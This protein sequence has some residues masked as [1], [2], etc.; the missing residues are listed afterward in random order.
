MNNKCLYCYKELTGQVDFHQVCSMEFFGTKEA[1]ELPYSLDQML[2]L[3]KYV[4]E[5][6]VSVPGVQAKLSMSLIKEVQ[7]RNKNRLTVVG[8]LG[9]NYIFKPPNNDFPDMPQNEHATMRIAEAMGLR[10]VPSSLIRLQSGELSYITKRIDRTPEGSKIH[11]L[12]MFQLTDAYDKYKS[13][14]E[15][16]GK[17]I[18]MYSDNTLLDL[19]Y[20]FELTIFSFLTGNN[21]MHLKNFSLISTNSRWILSPAYDLLNVSL[22]NPKDKEELALPIDGKK[23]KLKRMHFELFGSSLGLNS[24]QIS[25]V[26]NRYQ[27]SL[28]AVESMINQSF[29]SIEM[30]SKYSELYH[31]RHAILFL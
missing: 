31:D 17:A 16:I 2:E 21:D 11:M 22:L 6:S 5:R 24:K 27:A 12:D 4:V 1:P 20:L 25:G 19:L 3:A 10:V 23:K 8:A 18:S 9:G 13:S 29:L 14:M 7:Q 28:P 26:L 30:K 15:R